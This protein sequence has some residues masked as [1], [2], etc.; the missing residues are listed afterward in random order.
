[1]IAAISAIFLY[2]MIASLLGTLLPDLS[3]RFQMT[4]RQSGSIAG[5]QALGLM[6]ASVVAGALIDRVG[7]K[8]GFVSGLTLM[9]VALVALSNSAGWKSVMIAMFILGLGG[10]A[11]VTAANN[12]VSDIGEEKRGVLL[13]FVNIFFGL[14][15]MVT[16]FLAASLLRGN[17]MALAWVI[18][19]LAASLLVFDA[20][21]NMPAPVPHNFEFSQA[22]RL[23]GKRLLLLLSLFVFLYVACE[24][25][26]WNWLT[27]YLVSQGL[28]RSLALNILGFGFA[29][30]MIVG[31]LI[32]TRLLSRYSATSVSLVCSCLMVAATFWTLNAATPVAACLSVLCTGI[33]MGPVYPSAMAISGDAF[34]QMS[35]TRMGIV[36]TAGWM[37]AAASSWLIGLIA[38]GS[39][40]HLRM[41]LLLLPVFAAL[42]IAIN[43]G[44]RPLL[45]TILSRG[46]IVYDAPARPAI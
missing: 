20:T 46:R 35:A 1:M 30:G 45:A 38:G 14:G 36:I 26:V 21:T 34:R 11:V 2:G 42:M 23:P 18:A 19:T 12:L 6:L 5:L 27:K 22:L 16:P 39:D 25:A 7:K 9:V 24:V 33:V 29:S 4:P 44:L 10:G 15:G 41:A 3:A 28:S 8:A 43:L 32:G 40:R 37:G 17:S 31:R 13:S